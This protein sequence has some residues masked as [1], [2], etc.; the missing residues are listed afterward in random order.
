MVFLQ[1]F[2]DSLKLPRKKALFRLNRTGM[3][4]VVLYM[5]LLVFI[6][7]IPELIDQI[8]DPVKS[9]LTVNTFFLFIYFFIFYYLPL[10]V[11]IVI[12]FSLIAYI[13]TIITTLMKRKLRFQILWK[14]TTFIA[15]VP[16]I[17]YAIIALFFSVHISFLWLS[18][19]YTF[20]MLIKM[21]SIYPKRRIRKK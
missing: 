17:V 14:M 3:D 16:I 18:I 11:I 13:G 19:L 15:T 1:T 4:I 21:I 8:A 7:S 6:F 10:N 20:I 12:L 9:D 2:L 5:S